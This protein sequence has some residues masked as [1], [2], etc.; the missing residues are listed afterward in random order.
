MPKEP[1]IIGSKNAHT[2]S[3]PARRLCERER[4]LASIAEVQSVILRIACSHNF[5]FLQ[6]PTLTLLTPN[7]TMLSAQ[8]I[9][10]EFICPSL[11]VVLANVM[12]FA[13]VRDV[14][15]AL[16]ETGHLGDLNPT[17]WAFMLTNCLGWVTF[18]FLLKDVFVFLGNCPAL[19]LSVWLNMAAAKLQYENQ[20]SAAMR[21]SVIDALNEESSKRFT[22]PTDEETIVIPVVQSPTEYNLEDHNDEETGNNGLAGFS[23]VVVDVMSQHKPIPAPH[24]RLVVGLVA[25]WAA[26]ISLVALAS[27]MLNL[28]TRVMIVGLTVNLNLLFFYGAPLSTI[29]QVLKTR[30]SASIH[31]PTMITNTASATFWCLYGTAVMNLFIAIPN[32]IGVILGAVQIVLYVIFPRKTEDL[33]STVKSID[34]TMTSTTKEA[35]TVDNT[36]LDC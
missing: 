34:E 12:F 8:E 15:R 20:K 35:K 4:S 7:C 23:Q 24:E 6:N 19:I 31:V 36:V 21:K 3:N 28:D 1:R 5:S 22:L 30:S 29:T 10:L 11:G 17:P 26:V 14:C 33:D 2:K 32:A 13:P 25:V 18:S 27:D 16:N 9:V